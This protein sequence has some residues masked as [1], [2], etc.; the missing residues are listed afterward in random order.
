M[1]VV[2][3]A[4][5][6]LEEVLEDLAEDLAGALAVAHPDYQAIRSRRPTTEPTTPQRIR[7]PRD[8][9]DSDH[10]RADLLPDLVALL[11]DLRRFRLL[12]AA[13]TL[14]ENRSE[15][16]SMLT[17]NN[18]KL[19]R[20]RASLSRAEASASC[21]I[22]SRKAAFACHSAASVAPADQ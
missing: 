6:D 19:D 21:Q 7:P 8:Q 15:S 17:R 16:P 12:S 9:V 18:F 2:A 5:A 22:L 20:S 10:S 3:A 4:S 11:P 14:P 1:A 13:K